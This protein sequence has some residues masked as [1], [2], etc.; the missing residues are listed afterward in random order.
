MIVESQGKVGE[1]YKDGVSSEIALDYYE[2]GVITWYQV[3]DT[4]RVE[5]VHLRTKEGLVGGFWLKQDW[6]FLKRRG[7]V[8]FKEEPTMV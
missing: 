5:S 8:G 6:D 4:L 1:H 2:I 7:I 3:T